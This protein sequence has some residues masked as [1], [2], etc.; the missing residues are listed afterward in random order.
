MD[1]IQAAIL[2]GKFP[3]LDRCN[4]QR[5]QVA[6]WYDE[7]F[8][9]T[10]IV[11]P[12]G[13]KHRTHIFHQYTILHE[14]RDVIAN[15]LRSADIGCAIY[16]PVPLH[17]QT[18]MPKAYHELS[19]PN[20]EQAAVSCLSLPMFPG[21]TQKQVMQVAEHVLSVCSTTRPQGTEIVS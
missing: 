2:Q 11:R 1:E 3:H 18:M 15:A 13:A 10:G 6:H 12:Y 19:F 16:Y 8:A 5:G 14:N 21:M 4:D 17:Q 7:A 9:D 20:A